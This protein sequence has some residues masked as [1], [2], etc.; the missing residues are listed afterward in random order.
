VVDRDRH[1][2]P[3][4]G[5]GGYRNGNEGFIGIATRDSLESYRIEDVALD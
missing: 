5:I 3:L 2:A 1:G 4:V